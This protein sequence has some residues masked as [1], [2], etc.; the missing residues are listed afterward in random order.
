MH[1]TLAGA[2][3]G[4][5]DFGRE[6]ASVFPS[7]TEL[8][9]DTRDAASRLFATLSD[10]AWQQG[11]ERIFSGAGTSM[12]GGSDLFGGSIIPGILH[13]GGIAGVDG[14]DH[15]RRVSAAIFE[16]AE[17]YHNGGIA[18]LR[19]NEVPPILERGE[20]VIPN[21]Q[22]EKPAIGGRA[23]VVLHAPPGFSAEQLGQVESVAVR[24]VNTH[25]PAMVGGTMRNFNSRVMMKGRR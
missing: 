11:L 14:Y 16:D 19:S 12:K 17:H 10:R 25:G 2:A 7:I 8:M 23:E 22:S 21:G 13:D 3:D 9:D 6:A 5:T 20:R 4:I 18:G 24:V 1:E 15:S